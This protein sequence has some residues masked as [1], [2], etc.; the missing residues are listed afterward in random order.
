MKVS[1]GSALAAFAACALSMAP[2]H[3]RAASVDAEYDISL[4]GLT[5]GRANLT[6]G[7]DDRGYKLDL[8]A[9]LTGLVGGFTGGRGSGTST[10]TLAAGRR[11]HPGFPGPVVHG[12]GR[13]RVTGAVR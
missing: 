12:F 9:R 11:E 1:V 6:G 7:I 8:V 13:G 4:L 10:G 5:L 3:A 2:S